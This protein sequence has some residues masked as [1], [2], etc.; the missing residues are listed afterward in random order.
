MLFSD[1]VGHEQIKEHLRDT[2]RSGRVS[3]ALL[4]TG[5]VGVGALPM[6]LAYAQYLNC[7]NRGEHDSCGVCPECY[8][9]QRMEHPDVHYIYPVNNSKE[10][11]S[12]GR[13]DEKPRSDH[14]LHVWRRVTPSTGGYITEQQWYEALGIDN[15]QGIINKSDANELLRKMSFKAFEGGYKIVI[16]WLPERLHESAANTLLKLVEEPPE[17]T[18][19][20]LASSEPDKIIATIRSRTQIVALGAVPDEQIA[21]AL[22][23][24]RDMD[25]EAARHIAHLA[26]G[27]WGRALEL[28][29]SDASSNSDHQER[30][31]A[32]MRLCYGRK[33]LDLFGWAEEIAATGR[34][35]QK[36]FCAAAL[37]ILR[38]CYFTGIGLESLSYM[39]PV[40]ATFCRNF[41]P[42]VSD[43]TI[44]SF[45]E[46][47]ELLISQIARNGN[48]K[49]LFTH[50]AMSISKIIGNARSHIA[51]R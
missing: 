38:E 15:Q 1:I 7:R 11:Q 45:V 28:A 51:V 2:V 19:F 9:M 43:I 33:Y 12:T 30:F 18:I 23:Q 3:H 34:E 44:E 37:N 48:P 13:A 20:L 24:R 6:A 27:S 29:G 22:T 47:F 42:Y 41:A 21:Q 17:R 25:P 16:L 40:R 10:A 49:I 5:A 36:E 35:S 39:E 26:Q 46:E 14:F 8:R 4:I 31:I 32:L 50:F